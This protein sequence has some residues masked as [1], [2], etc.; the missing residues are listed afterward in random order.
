MEWIII[1][2][3]IG[4]MMGLTGSGG[5]LVAIPL[6]MSLL[7]KS[8]KE[9]S[10]LSLYV[11][12][13]ASFVN[14]YSQRR[15]AQYKLAIWVFLGSV[16]GSLATKPL[17]EMSSDLVIASIL[18]VVSLFSL[19]HIWK[20]KQFSQELVMEI[21]PL[22]SLG[23]GLVLGGLTTMTGLGG[24]VLL[25]PVFLGV[26]KLSESKAVATSLLTITFS[27]LVSLLL[28][29][30]D[31]KIVLGIMELGLLVVGIM[32]SLLGLKFFLKRL[33][34]EKISVVRKI[35]FTFIVFY[36]LVKIF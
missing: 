5:A 9:A 32:A 8:L 25:M 27:S 4:L 14:F 11:V 15:K 29:I 24:G 22:K 34:E 26:F 10:I 1:G 30:K 17:K 7:D 23:L 19:Y 13:L 36:S 3:I 33:S 31:L 21:N 28:Q 2:T 16:A 18:G 20:K 35:V 12:I 6:F